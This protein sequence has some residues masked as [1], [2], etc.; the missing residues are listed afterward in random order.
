[1]HVFVGIGGRGVWREG[2]GACLWLQCVVL[3]TANALS[4]LMFVWVVLGGMVKT[5][6]PSLHIFG[7]SILGS[8][9]CVVHN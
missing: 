2:G 8:S 4:L 6:N 7:A 3:L 9:L 5:P 1:M